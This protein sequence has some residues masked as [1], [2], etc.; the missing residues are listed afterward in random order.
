MH[1]EQTLSSKE[2]RSAWALLLA[3]VYEVDILRCG[4]CGSPMKVL[5]VFTDPPQVRRILL[6]LI[7]TG[8]APG[9]PRSDTESD[10]EMPHVTYFTAA[11]VHTHTAGS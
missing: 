5:A 10:I 8:L 1:A 4:R 11:D 9:L 7:K 6:H 3:K 2:S